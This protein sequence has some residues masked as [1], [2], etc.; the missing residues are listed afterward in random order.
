MA[1]DRAALHGA[2]AAADAE[3]ETQY[4]ALAALAEVV[5]AYLAAEPDTV[6]IMFRGL[7][8]TFA[9]LD[10]AEEVAAEKC[11]VDHEDRTILVVP[12]SSVTDS[13]IVARYKGVVL[14]SLNEAREEAADG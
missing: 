14:H 8:Q 4:S 9:D 2:L 7:P 13:G 10:V 12:R 6:F 5:R 3:T 11:E 1:T